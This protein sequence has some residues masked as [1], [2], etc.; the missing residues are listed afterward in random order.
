MLAP[1]ALSRSNALPSSFPPT[2]WRSTLKSRP[3]RN[4]DYSR[5]IKNLQR[6]AATTLGHYWINMHSPS[7]FVMTPLDQ[8]QVFRQCGYLAGGNDGDSLVDLVSFAPRIYDPQVLE[9]EIV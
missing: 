5:K 2:I 4:T 6:C 8:G 7:M 9:S 3:D 1:E